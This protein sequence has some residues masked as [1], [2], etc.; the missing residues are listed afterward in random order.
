MITLVSEWRDVTESLAVEGDVQGELSYSVTMEKFGQSVA[1]GIESVPALLPHRVNGT[2]RRVFLID[3]EPSVRHSL[4][5]ELSNSGYNVSEAGTAIDGIRRFADARPDA[6]ILDI[7][8]P[9]LDGVDVIRYLRESSTVPIIVLSVR[10]GETDKIAALDAG[11][12]DYLTK[13]FSPGE[14]MARLRAALRRTHSTARCEVFSSG[15][16]QVDLARRVVRVQG[17]RVQLTPI[18]YGLLQT[19]IRYAGRLVTYRELIREVWGWGAHDHD[20]HLLRV[21]ISNLRRKLRRDP[22]HPRY[23]IT[24]QGGGYRLRT[25]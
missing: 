18:E 11:A 5:T 24:V 3:F 4:R 22:T 9:D 8:V 16:L 20:V 12:D 25:E 1:T 15:D 13:P 10:H 14:L 2:G 23:I 19:L 6:I 21:N 17:M 7:A